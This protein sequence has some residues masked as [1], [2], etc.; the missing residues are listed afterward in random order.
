MANQGK[1]PKV[2]ERRKTMTMNWDGLADDDEDHFFESTTRFSSVAPNDFPI[3]LPSSGSDDD[4]FEDSRLSFTTSSAA[5]LAS[6]RRASTNFRNTGVTPAGGP[7]P[8]MFGDYDMWTAEPGS[9]QERRKKLFQG[10]GLGSNKNGLAV[11]SSKSMI[12]PALSQKRLPINNDTLYPVTGKPSL[13]NEP[14]NVKHEED[15]LVDQEQIKDEPNSTVVEEEE[16]ILIRSRSDGDIGGL[17]ADTRQRKTEMI[18]KMSKQRL[19]RTS[20]VL[21]PRAR[22]A[23]HFPGGLTKPPPK[24]R[25]GKKQPV[26]KNGELTPALQNGQVGAFFLIKNLDTDKEFIVKE[27]NENGTWNKLS[28]VQTGKQ[29][30]MEEFEK[31]VGH[32]PVV[33]DLMRRKRTGDL[34]DGKS[35]LSGS[36]VFSKSLRYSKRRGASIIKNIKGVA[37]NMTATKVTDKDSPDSPPTTAPPPAE[38][39]QTN[40]NPN[41]ASA[42]A[43]SASSPWVKVRTQG[44]STKE[45]TALHL[46]QEIQAHESSIW[47]IKFSSDGHYLASGG[48][49]RIIH[50]WEVQECDVLSGKQAIDDGSSLDPALTPD[51]KKDRPPLAELSPM[52]SEKKKKGKSSIANKGGPNA[53]PDYVHV[54]ETMFSLSE[55]PVFSLTG[56]QDEVLDLCWSKSRVSF[57]RS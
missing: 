15:G 36:S 9:I 49:D 42:S 4:E 19:T 7:P 48:E 16:I 18:G 32:C 37:N 41:P 52:P 44:V 6:A 11:V 23:S 22:M 51:R 50:V 24:K 13:D 45:F 10:M 38:D 40:K 26:T 27:F 30:T 21:V 20:S 43:A 56:H 2:M 14:I 8:P 57:P 28:E 46:C 33:K 31:S 5:Y 34:A 55:K 29:L 39:Q 1:M 25:K 17:S 54:P 12:P 35:K 47:T 3:D 53:M